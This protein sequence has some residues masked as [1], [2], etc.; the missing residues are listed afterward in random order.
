MIPRGE[1][2]AAPLE[3]VFAIVLLLVLVLGAIEVAYALYARNVISASAHEGARTAIE[4]GRDPEEAA[5]I[6]HRTVTR[7]AGGLVTGLE[8]RTQMSSTEDHSLVRVT[9][10]G[11]L[12]AWGPVPLPIEL[13]STATSSSSAPGPQ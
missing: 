10:S 13:T 5:L 1:R 12:R 7:S 3:S 9:V 2:G 8:V 11:R 6:A 4:M